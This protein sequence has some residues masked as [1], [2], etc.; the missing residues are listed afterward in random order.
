MV[1]HGIPDG[2]ALEDG[3]VLAVDVGVTLDGFVGDSAWTFPVGEISP[4][5]ERLLE[6]CEASLWAGLEQARAGN[7]LSD[8]SHAIQAV[9]EEAGFSVIRALVGHGVGRS[10]H[11]DPQIPNFGPPGRGPVLQEGM[12]LAIE[13]MITAGGPDVYLHEDEWSIST[14][15]GSLAA[16]FEHTV[17]I[18]AAGPRILT[19]APALLR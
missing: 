14:S 4:E 1:V 5:A 18:T 19:K 2:Y 16:H 12:T 7:H 10:M 9:V 8:I 17:A 13:P 6:V 11:E 15:D 3:D